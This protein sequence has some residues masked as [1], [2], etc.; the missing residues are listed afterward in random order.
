MLSILSNILSLKVAKGEKS[1]AD[2]FLKV[3]NIEILI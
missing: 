2:I 3:I 1:I